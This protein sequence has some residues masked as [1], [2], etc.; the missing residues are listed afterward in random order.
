MKKTLIF[1]ILLSS[2]VFVGNAQ[3]DSSPLKST[4]GTATRY[5]GG[6]DKDKVMD[7]F[8]N[9]QFDEAIG[10]LSPVLKADSDNLTVLTYAGYAYFMEDNGAAAT[11]C[12]HRLL[13]VDSNSIT[14]LHYLVLLLQNST[15]AEALGYA[16][17]LLALQPVKS[18][19][20]R[21]VGELWR[22]QQRPDS[23]LAYLQRAYT[24]APTDLKT[25]TD[26]GSVLI[27][28]RA[29]G[30]ADSLIDLGLQLDSVN[31]SLL[32][33]RV[34]GAYW[35]KH[36]EEA[37]VPGERLLRLQEP[38]VNALEWLS[39]SYYNLKQY[40]DCIRVCEGMQELGLDIEAVYYYESRAQAKLKNYSESDSL[41]YKALSKAISPTAEWYYDDLG[42]NYESTHDY[43]RAVAHYDTAFYLFRNP[44]ALYTC[45][46]I[47]ETELH[48]ASRARQYFR[49]YLALARPQTAEEKKVYAYVRKRYGGK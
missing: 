40:P 25:I 6:V 33:L 24:L 44:I 16:S 34:Q 20:W 27:D 12:Y 37:F 7:L 30:Q 43:R 11:A 13:G 3:M 41:L 31:V 32:K 45:G 22:R 49:R 23:A 5:A 47:C 48:E 46:R 1:L 29:Y 17:R 36:Y 8:E 15:T 4:L 42:D 10:Y 26:L 38:A 21:T 28:G 2:V 9:Q 19:W 35:S 18:V 14:G 39:L